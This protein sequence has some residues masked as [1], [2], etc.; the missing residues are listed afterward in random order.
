MRIFFLLLINRTGGSIFYFN[1]QRKVISETQPILEESI[2][3]FL[4]QTTFK[5]SLKVADLGCSS[6]PNALL[7]VYKILTIINETKNNSNLEAPILQVYLN[8]LFGNDFSGIFKLLPDFYQG[9]QERGHN[10]GACLIHATPG[11]FYGRLFPN[12]Y[13][14]FFHSSSSLHWLSQAPEELTTGE[15]PLNKGHIHITNTSPE[16][17]YKAYFEQFQRDFKLFLRSRSDELTVG[18]SM[19]LSFLGRENSLFEIGTSGALIGMILN[20]MVLEVWLKERDIVLGLLL[21]QQHPNNLFLHVTATLY[22]SMLTMCNSLVSLYRSIVSL[23][24]STM[25]L[26]RSIVHL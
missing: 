15:E 19:L 14:N 22:R 25:S 11:N 17:V 16:I 6:G 26:Y 5:S 20:D 3:R 8:D 4:H 10:N 2:K 24:R 23:Y 12:N 7:V 21:Q 13:I 1:F 18:G 9:V